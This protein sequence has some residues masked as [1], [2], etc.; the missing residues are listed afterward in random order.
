MFHWFRAFL[1]AIGVVVG[2]SPTRAQPVAIPFASAKPAVPVVDADRLRTLRDTVHSHAASASEGANRLDTVVLCP[3]AFRQAITTWVKYRTLQGHGIRVVDGE[4]PSRVLQSTIRDLARAHPIRYVVIVGDADPMMAS[5]PDMRARCV[6]TF[7]AKARVNQKWGSEPFIAT[8]NPYGDLDDDQIPELAVGRIPCD[9]VQQLTTIIDKTIHYETCLVPG[10]W[11][12][13]IHLVAGIGGFGAIADAAIEGAA[14]K[15]ITDMIPAEYVTTVTYGSWRSPFCPD[16]R[17]FREAWLERVNSGGLFWVYMGHGNPNRLDHLTF[18]DSSVPVLEPEDVDKLQSTVGPPIAVL[19]ACYT[20]AFRPI[21]R[22]HRRKNDSNPPRSGRCALW[23]TC[24]DALWHGRIQHFADVCLLSRKNNG[25][26]G[27][28]SES[29]KSHGQRGFRTQSGSQSKI[30]RRNRFNA[31]PQQRRISQRAAR[32]RLVVSIARRSV[33]GHRSTDNHA[34]RL[35]ATHR[36]RPNDT[37]AWTK[38]HRWQ[39]FDRTGMPTRSLNDDCPA[40]F[41][42]DEGTRILGSDD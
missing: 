37:G 29:Q 25:V 42:M 1:V 5:D 30:A 35:P 40:A 28:L 34:D 17:Y 20:G 14:K 15:F 3:P 13:Q 7:Y 8:D 11:R 36:S 10:L 9:S 6:P 24:D 38:P 22:L 12:R 2:V 23:V 32:T 4:Q 19:L 31:Q 39:V 27:R 41:A 33:A 21:G 26:G 18:G 16:P